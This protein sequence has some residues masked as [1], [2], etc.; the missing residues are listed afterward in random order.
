MFGC[1]GLAFANPAN[2]PTMQAA[3]LKV[4]NVCFM[5]M[6][7]TSGT[8]SESSQLNYILLIYF[9]WAWPRPQPLAWSLMGFR[10]PRIVAGIL[11]RERRGPTT[12]PSAPNVNVVN[13]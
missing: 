3:A 13:V 5:E 12:L 1:S 2:P 9:S 6:P 8:V 4:M 10:Q 11:P 7:L